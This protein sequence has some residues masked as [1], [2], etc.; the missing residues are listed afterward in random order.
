MNEHHQVKVSTGMRRA[1]ANL[2]HRTGDERSLEQ[3]VEAAPKAWLAATTVADPEAAAAAARGYQW[4]S[5]F[6]PEGCQLR[7]EHHGEYHVATVCGDRILYQ[8][9]PYLPRQFVMQVTGQV[10]N[11]WLALW[12]HCPGDA[13]AP[14][15]HAPPYPAPHPRSHCLPIAFAALGAHGPAQ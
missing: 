2:L 7:I 11:A 12:I 3:V 8:G 1:V 5:L 6:L 13:L 14:G 10:R 9:R 15:R 4:K